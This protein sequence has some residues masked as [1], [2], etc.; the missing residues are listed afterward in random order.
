M[1]RNIFYAKKK[2]N[3][4]Y[5]TFVADFLLCMLCMCAGQISYGENE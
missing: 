4:E 5:Q 1:I 3:W 2:K